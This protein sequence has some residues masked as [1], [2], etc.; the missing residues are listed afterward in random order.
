M[1]FALDVGP[2]C[3]LIGGTWESLHLPKDNRSAKMNVLMIA[4][5]TMLRGLKAV[6]KTGPFALIIIPEMQ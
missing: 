2:K 1:P 3:F 5:M 4:T 6:T